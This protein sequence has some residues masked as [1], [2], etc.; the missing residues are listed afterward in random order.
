MIE[1]NIRRK[2]ESLIQR[3]SSLVSLGPMARDTRHLAQ[4]DGWITEALNIVSR[5]GELGLCDGRRPHVMS[6]NPAAR[7]GA[8]S[9]FDGHGSCR[10]RIACGDPIFQILVDFGFGPWPGIVRA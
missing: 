4:C 5:V 9:H 2:I 10:N 1:E 6:R 7:H 8:G 3:S